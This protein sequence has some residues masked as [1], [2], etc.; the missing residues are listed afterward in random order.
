M[1]QHFGLEPDAGITLAN[2]FFNG[3]VYTRPE[4]ASMCEQLG[5]GDTL[6]ELV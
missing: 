4:D 5:F 3:F 1:L 2:N 6:M